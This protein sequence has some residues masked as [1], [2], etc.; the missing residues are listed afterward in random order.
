MPAS[1][2]ASALAILTFIAVSACGGAGAP[3]APSS[4]N[5]PTGAPSAAGAGTAATRNAP[6]PVRFAYT[7]LSTTIAP[8]WIAMEAGYFAE[9]GVDVQATYFGASTVGM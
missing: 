7:A 8:Y 4:G 5:A 1:P 2:T 3:P 6:L 9:E